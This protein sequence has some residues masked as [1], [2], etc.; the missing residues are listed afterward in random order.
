MKKILFFSFVTL[1][2]IFSFKVYAQDFLNQDKMNSNQEFRDNGYRII[3]FAFRHHGPLVNNHCIC[4]GCVCSGCPCPLGICICT[5][6]RPVTLGDND[7]L[8]QDQID[9]GYGIAWVKIVNNQ[10]HL[11]FK[12][13]NDENGYM[14]V[15]SSP[16]ADDTDAPKF[17][18]SG[19]FHITN[20]TYQVIKTKYDLGETVVDITF[21]HD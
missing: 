14:E 3:G 11:I 7:E 5:N 13:T 2:S 9:A 18:A 21:D 16:A 15:D 10:M 12:T 6:A 8:T 1:I 19:N 20:N 4:P 17:G